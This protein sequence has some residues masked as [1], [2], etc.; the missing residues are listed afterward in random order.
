MSLG[1]WVADKHLQVITTFFFQIGVYNDAKCT[2][3][4]LNH[5]VLVVGYGKENGMDYWLVKNRY[6]SPWPVSGV[7]PGLMTVHSYFKMLWS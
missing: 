7:K 2:S 6:A 5:A 1:S 3:Q 4:H